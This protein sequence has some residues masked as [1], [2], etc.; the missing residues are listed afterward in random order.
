ML[1]YLRACGFEMMGQDRPWG[2]DVYADP[3]IGVVERRS[4]R[5]ADNAGLSRD[6]GRK[7]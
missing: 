1:L 5:K 7:T 2:D 6:I 4:L 3:L